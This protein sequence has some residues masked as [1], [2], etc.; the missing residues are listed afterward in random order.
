MDVS[1]RNTVDTRE[2][3]ANALQPAYVQT[4]H[5]LLEA[6]IAPDTNVI[7]QVS[8]RDRATT[9]R[10]DCDYGSDKAPPRAS[11]AVFSVIC[12]AVVP[13]PKGC[14]RANEQPLHNGC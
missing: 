4:L 8:D 9:C 11:S 14:N 5:G 3:A 10:I 6:T 13:V 12:A 7:K 2:P 1:S